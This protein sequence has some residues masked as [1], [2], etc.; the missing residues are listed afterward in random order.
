MAQRYCGN[1]KDTYHELSKLIRGVM[2][3]RK[4]LVEY[5]RTKQMTKSPDTEPSTPIIT[6]STTSTTSLTLSNVDVQVSCYTDFVITQDTISVIL[7]MGK[8]RNYL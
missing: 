2:A 1:C 3:S 4:E 7:Y 6:T 5:D 8:Q